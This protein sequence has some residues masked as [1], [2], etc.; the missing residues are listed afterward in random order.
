MRESRMTEPNWSRR[1]SALPA[2][3]PP[4]DAW[5]AI[6]ARLEAR[7]RPRRTWPVMGMAAAMVMG[8]SL[9]I[10]QGSETEPAMHAAPWLAQS[11]RLERRLDALPE[12]AVMSGAEARM[13]AEIE[14][15]IALV[16]LQLAS[17]AVS[18][19]EAE[20]LWQRRVDLLLDLMAVRSEP[21]Y[22]AAADTF[23]L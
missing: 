8:L 16:D 1:L 11:Q 4:R 20:Y 14:D 18:P 17:G 23:A 3:A 12:S 7:R 13:V 10:W 2:Q 9:W 22:V 5:P 6:R 21:A 15:R 19:Q